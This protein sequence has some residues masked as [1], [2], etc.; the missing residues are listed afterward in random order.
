MKPVLAPGALEDL[1]SRFDIKPNVD[2]GSLTGA[3]AALA[4]L[5]Q[6][7]DEVGAKNVPVNV[8]AGNAEGV[9]SK[10]MQILGLLS[11]IESKYGSAASA[12]RSIPSPNAGGGARTGKVSSA[13][14]GSFTDQGM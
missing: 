2:A 10:L 9:I 4:S 1:K 14:S 7:M 6:K 13:L 3:E 8:N 5:G 12:V 11:Q